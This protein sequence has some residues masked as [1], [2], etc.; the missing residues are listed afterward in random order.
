MSKKYEYKYVFFVTQWVP[1][2]PNLLSCL[3]GR[4]YFK[5][6][7]EEEEEEEEDVEEWLKPCYTKVPEGSYVIIQKTFNTEMTCCT[8]WT[9]VAIEVVDEDPYL[10][11]LPK[12]SEK[13]GIKE[14]FLAYEDLIHLP[15]EEYDAW[16]F[17][18][19]KGQARGVLE[20]SDYESDDFD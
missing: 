11:R 5:V 1:E 6:V 10:T 4:H 20:D 3:D 19:E 9:N 8:G 7:P 17:L 2:T 18:I 16:C 15:E 12:S 14:F 13:E